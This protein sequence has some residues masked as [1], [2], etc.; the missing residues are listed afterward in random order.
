MKKRVNS[1]YSHIITHNLPRL[2]VVEFDKNFYLWSCSLGVLN[3][4]VT[5][6][7]VILANGINLT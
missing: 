1:R 2:P 3:D 5:A 7:V 6:E 4:M